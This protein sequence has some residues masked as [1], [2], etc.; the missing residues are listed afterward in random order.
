MKKLLVGILVGAGLLVIWLALPQKVTAPVEGLLGAN[1]PDRCEFF[2]QVASRSRKALVKS[3]GGTLYSYRIVST[4][5]N[6][7]YFR[8][9]DE[10]SLPTTG[11]SVE[12]ATP[13][14]GTT[15]SNS[16]VVIEEKFAVPM[17][18]DNGIAWSLSDAFGS[19]TSVSNGA[20]NSYFVTLCYE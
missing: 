19:W 7:R 5:T 11:A 20:L 10:A 1:I 12:Y 18:F 15:A 13:L 14:G 6:L 8:I 17:K 2:D 4:A 9:H 16:P 3:A